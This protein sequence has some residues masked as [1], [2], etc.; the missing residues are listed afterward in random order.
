MLF[1]LPTLTNNIVILSILSWC[2][3]VN[4]FDVNLELPEV[5]PV[6][7]LLLIIHLL[8]QVGT[9][10]HFT[11]YDRIC[12]L[13]NKQYVCAFGTFITLLNIGVLISII[14][15]SIH[16]HTF[17]MCLVN[18]TRDICEKMIRSEYNLV[19]LTASI[20]ISVFNMCL[21]LYIIINQI[22]SYFTYND[23]I[24]NVLSSDN[25]LD[26][27]KY[28]VDGYLKYNRVEI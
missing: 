18:D 2:Y 19:N 20:M 17:K 25:L 9:T 6:C 22:Y 24:K 8:F 26:N 16:Y 7:V 5:M 23:S 4:Y 28:K 15:L 13:H 3:N 11:Y 21:T 27:T 1:S 12:D 10:I 14:Q